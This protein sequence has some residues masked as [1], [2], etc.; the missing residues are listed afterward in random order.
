MKK[1]I[2]SIISGSVEISSFPFGLE[3]TE[4]VVWLSRTMRGVV[5]GLLGVSTGDVDIVVVDDFFCGR[6]RF[7]QV[8][9]I[10]VKTGKFDGARR[11]RILFRLLPEEQAA[12]LRPIEIIVSSDDDVPCTITVRDRFAGKDVLWQQSF[13]RYSHRLSDPQRAGDVLTWHWTRYYRFLTW[14]DVEDLARDFGDSAVGLTLSEAN[15]L[16][17]R[18]LYHRAR[19]QGWRKLTLR[20]QSRWQL[21]GQWH[22]DD[23]CIA[24]RT[25]LGAPNGAS[26]ATNRATRPMGRL[27]AY[28]DLAQKFD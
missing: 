6:S 13:A 4:N 22:R 14:C 16:A 21:H 23:D 5:S 9:E 1:P 10:S 12:V 8:A 3:S 2:E 17:S 28:E 20:E 25:K 7:S 15:R 11:I 26:Q 24:A 18:Q 27:D 19:Q